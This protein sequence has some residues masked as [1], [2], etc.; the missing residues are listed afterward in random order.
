MDIIQLYRLIERVS[1]EE[2]NSISSLKDKYEGDI[3]KLNVYEFTD[4]I[5]I[6]LI[7]VKDKSSGVGTKIMNDICDIADKEN[8]ICILTPS[9]EFG[10][11]KSRLIKFYKRFGFVENKGKNKDFTIFETMYRLPIK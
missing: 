6:D 8:K 11:S 4:K 7:V 3:D 9:D 1:V 5:S 2:S 10:G